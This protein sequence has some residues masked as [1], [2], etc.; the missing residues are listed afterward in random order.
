MPLT[1]PVQSTLHIG[2]I[3]SSDPNSRSITKSA[4]LYA[5]SARAVKIICIFMTKTVLSAA[6]IVAHYFTA[7]LTCLWI[8]RLARG[9]FTEARFEAG[10]WETNKI[11]ARMR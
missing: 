4:P 7:A 8:A 11:S 6:F 1:S 9:P 10:L 5:T 3:G 2:L